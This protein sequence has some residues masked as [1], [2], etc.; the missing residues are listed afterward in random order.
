MLL[1]LRLRFSPFVAVMVGP[2]VRSIGGGRHVRE[3]VRTG[4]DVAV[5]AAVGERRLLPLRPDANYDKPAHEQVQ[6]RGDYVSGQ[7]S[8]IKKGYQSA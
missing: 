1:S 3:G 2:F 4:G 8:A 7:H 6:H 5:E